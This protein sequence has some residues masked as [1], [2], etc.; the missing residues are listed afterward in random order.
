MNHSWRIRS[1]STIS[2][3]GLLSYD[4]IDVISDNK[5]RDAVY[6][7]MNMGVETVRHYKINI[8]IINHLPTKGRDTIRVLNEASSFT[9]F[10]HSANAKIKY[11]LT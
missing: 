4:D 3:T 9:Y 5:I 7:I 2:Q 8:V 10:P 6:K 11:V 1:T